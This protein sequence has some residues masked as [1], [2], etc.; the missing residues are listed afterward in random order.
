MIPIEESRSVHMLESNLMVTSKIRTMANSRSKKLFRGSR[1]LVLLT[2][3]LLMASYIVLERVA[4]SVSPFVSGG[5]TSNQ[6]DPAT[7]NG[8]LIVCS[9]AVTPQCAFDYPP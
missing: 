7:I 4:A 1:V 6:F 9:D 3:I 5:L 8:M 2:A